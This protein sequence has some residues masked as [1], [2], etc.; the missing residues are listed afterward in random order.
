MLW[1]ENWHKH[2]NYDLNNKKK[3]TKHFL[4]DWLHEKFILNLKRNQNIANESN[5]HISNHNN[6]KQKQNQK[7]KFKTTTN[8][9]KV[10]MNHKI[11]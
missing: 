7:K 8:T 11:E 4:N 1:K 6:L 2:Y 5:S 10:H 3:K 9:S